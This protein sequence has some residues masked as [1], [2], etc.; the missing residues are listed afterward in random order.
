VENRNRRFP[1]SFLLLEL[2]KEATT[3]IEPINEAGVLLHAAILTKILKDEKIVA[4][5]TDLDIEYVFG[6][7]QAKLESSTAAKPGEKRSGKRGFGEYFIDWLNEMQPEELCFYLAEY[8]FYKAKTIYS[9][10]D[11]DDVY[12]MTEY[13]VKRE[14]EQNRILLEA[15][16]FGFGGGYD[17]GA[18]KA[19]DENTFDLTAPSSEGMAELAKIF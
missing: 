19:A 12:K 11:F 17:D 5:P 7:L 15:S 1:I 3:G 6:R 18:K 10:L 13:K 8:D 14:F 16:A 9:E 4:K 2:I